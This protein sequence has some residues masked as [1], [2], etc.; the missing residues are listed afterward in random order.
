MGDWIELEGGPGCCVS[1]RLSVKL[2]ASSKE[3]A[4]HHRRGHFATELWWGGGRLR[5]QAP[6][7]QEPYGERRE[8]RGAG[9]LRERVDC[10][11]PL[12]CASSESLNPLG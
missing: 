6:H 12:G 7:G 11:R 9:S 1:G 5:T 10:E 8:A 2:L 3:Q 4:K